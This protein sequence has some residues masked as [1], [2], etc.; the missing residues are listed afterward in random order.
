[1]NAQLLVMNA[2]LLVMNAQLNSVNNVSVPRPW[3]VQYIT[4]N[5]C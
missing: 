5:C 4:N 1:M 3:D 2:Q